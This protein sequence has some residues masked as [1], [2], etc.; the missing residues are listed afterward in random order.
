[1]NFVRAVAAVVLALAGQSALG[2]VWPEGHRFVDLMLAAVVWYGIAHTQRGAML[3]GCAGGLLQDSWFQLGLFGAEGFKKTLIGW[4]LGALSVRVDLNHAAG[5]F[6]TGGAMA[7]VD[8]LADQLVP[9]LLDQRVEWP[10]TGALVTRIVT[11]GLL[12]ATIGGIVD[13]RRRRRT[14]FRE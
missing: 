1:V 3:V 10:A 11:T 2:R 5:R 9:K 12:V 8:V 4:I 13:R 7:V 6:V 14:A